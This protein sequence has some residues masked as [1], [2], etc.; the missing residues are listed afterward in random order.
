[1][2]TDA[3]TVTKPD[4]PKEKTARPRLP[5]S[6]FTATVLVIAGY[7]VSSLG[8]D[9]I[10]LVYGFLR[11][12]TTGQ[13]QLWVSSST[14]AQFIN[15]LLVYGIIVGLVILFM[16]VRKVPLT[17]IGAVRPRFEDAAIALAAAP[18]YMVVY[19]ALLMA[20]SALIPGLDLNQGQQLGFDKYQQGFT[21]FLT[22]LSLVVLPP[23]AEEFVMRGFLFT[24]LI[25]RMRFVW[26]AI[27]VSA[28]FGAAHLQAGS[29]QPLLW[30][31]A[32]DTFVLSLVLCYIRWKT[33][34]LWASIFLHMIKNLIAFM[35]IFVFH[36]G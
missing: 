27:L 21:L 32:V 30:T 4:G 31:A 24:S 29:G 33:G 11:G 16:R 22:F 5:W 13:L 25:S 12:W 2:T 36:K 34:S 10:F 26:A 6:V 20:L 19:I 9:A 23:L 35:V 28:L 1:M 17:R 18:I 8:A 3:D 15:F 14:V 7:Y